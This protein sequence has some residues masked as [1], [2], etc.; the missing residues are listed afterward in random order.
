LRGA[1]DGGGPAARLRVLTTGPAA[2]GSARVESWSVRHPSAHVVPFPQWS[3]WQSHALAQL[4]RIDVPG[5]SRDSRHPRVEAVRS[6]ARFLRDYSD[7]SG[8]FVWTAPPKRSG[9]ASGAARLRYELAVTGHPGFKNPPAGPDP[10]RAAKPPTAESR[11]MARNVLR[12][13]LRVKPGEQV[14]ISSWTSTLPEANAFVLESLALGARPFL[15]YQDEAT[16]WAAAADTPVEHLGRLGRHLK[17]AIERTDVLVSFFGPSDRE[18]FHALPPDVLARL[19][20][21]DDD[22]YAAAARAGARAVQMALG[23]ASAASARMYGVNLARWRTELV[24]GSL[25]APAELH[26]RGAP[27]AAALS[28]G[29][30]LRISHPNGTDLTL[31]LKR[32][33]ARLADGAVGP[34]R[35]GGGWSLVTVPAGV[36]TVAVDERYAEGTF[37][38]NVPSSVGLSRGVGEFAG[39]R[40][41]FSRGRLARYAYDDGGDLFAESYAGAGPGRDLPGSVSIGLNDAISTA[42]L[43]EDQGTGTVT[44]HIGRNDYLGGS[45]DAD[46]WA[47]LYLRGADVRVDGRPLVTRGR[48][49]A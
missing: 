24:R 38:S 11:E 26:R 14:T 19:C 5:R 39:G 15:Q 49:P 27:I 17:A 40:W 7:A 12:R 10:M 20:D 37:R 6:I 2:T 30:E 43:L 42:P 21:L 47:W 33:P 29:R 48:L 28:K 13:C 32:R 8:P 1:E 36:V 4:R 23:R 46:W 3:S 34:A 45:N 9:T 22:I 31:R 35:R 16:Y 18:R 25:V 41:T 44:F